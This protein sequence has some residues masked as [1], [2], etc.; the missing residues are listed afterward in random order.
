LQD[1][2]ERLLTRDKLAA[3]ELQIYS[4]LSEWVSSR[5]EES[6]K[7]EEKEELATSVVRVNNMS[8]EELV[9]TVLVGGLVPS[10]A[11]HQAIKETSKKLEDALKHLRP[12]LHP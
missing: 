11:V 8:I 1:L 7:Q 4:A 10:A 5:P 9:D 12:E 6:L 2:L 3:T